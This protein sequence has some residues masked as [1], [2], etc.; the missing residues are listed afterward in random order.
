MISYSRVALMREQSHAEV[1]FVYGG[2][3]FWIQNPGALAAL[4]FDW[5]K[6]QVVP[7]GTLAALPAK[8]LDTTDAVKASDV[9]F[10]PDRGARSCRRS[11]R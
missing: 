3:K 4:G 6:V 11:S 1:Y 5:S 9:F 7:D 8:P 2:A 10:D